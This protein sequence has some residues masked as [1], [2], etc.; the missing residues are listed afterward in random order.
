MIARNLT[1]LL[2]TSL[3][4]AQNAPLH[5]FLYNWDRPQIGEGVSLYVRFGQAAEDVLG[6]ID[7]DDYRDWAI[8]TTGQKRI[9]GFVTYVLDVDDTTRESFTVVGYN[10]DP[11]RPD[12]PA[13][14]A[15]YRLGPVQMPPTGAT[16]GT[17]A[18]RLAAAFTNP[19][20]LAGSGDVFLGIGVPA[21]VVAGGAVTDGLFVGSANN[22]SSA[23]PPATFDRPGPR[24]A[25]GQGSTIGQGSYVCYNRTSGAGP[26]Y[27]P[28]NATSLEQLAIDA[29]VAD[30]T[31]G[32]VA[33]AETNQTSYLSSGPGLGTSNFLSGM[34]PDIN[35]LNGGRADNIGFAVTTGTAQ[36]P[37][38]NPVFILMALGPSP[39]GSTPLTTIAGGAAGPGSAGNVCIDFTSAAT[40][41]TTLVTGQANSFNIV[42]EAQLNVPLN[43]G[44][45]AVIGSIAGPV[46]L[47]WQGFALDLAAAGPGLE[48]RASG[49]AI[50]HLK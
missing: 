28:A 5:G 42:A 49:C 8:G 6:R 27:L 43:A 24:G 18:Y 19:Q 11:A 38:G 46:D 26:I 12:F 20:S 9:G 16:P 34:H 37:A 39:I 15:A 4:C 17:V 2:F 25:F 33:L 40:F 36:V 48:I 47:W 14:T 41:L 7:A 44:V 31:I 35:G 23:A 1:A 30:G 21:A 22:D 29:F 45:R 10:E 50:Q 13:A 3:A 32:G